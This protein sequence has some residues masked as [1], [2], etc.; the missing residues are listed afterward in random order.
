M[1]QQTTVGTVEKKFLIF[2][3]KYPNFKSFLNSSEKELLF[4]WSGLGY[5]RRARNLWNA[6][7]V[8][9]T[10]YKSKI[11]SEKNLLMSLPGVGSY[12]SSA[13]RTIGYNMPDTPVDTNIHRL[14]SGLFGI[15]LKHKQIEQIL[16]FIWPKSQSR[17][18][19]EALMDL[20]SAIKK[21]ITYRLMI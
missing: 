21:K 20:A 10:V 4:Y 8:I 18:F 15:E 13:I 12:T 6:I 14:F 9:N 17:D 5:Y 16:E 1:L 19:T 2:T 7:N 3:K 11:P